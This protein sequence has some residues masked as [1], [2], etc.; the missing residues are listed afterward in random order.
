VQIIPNKTCSTCR[1]KGE[2]HLGDENTGQN[3]PCSSCGPLTALAFLLTRIGSWTTSRWDQH[4]RD[5]FGDEVADDLRRLLDR[6]SVPLDTFAAQKV[7]S[8]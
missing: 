4:V 7:R 3:H 6:S 2:V 5:E 8:V 1:G